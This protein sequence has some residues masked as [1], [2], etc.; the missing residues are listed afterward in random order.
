[1]ARSEKMENSGLLSVMKVVSQSSLRYLFL[2]LRILH[3]Y[4]MKHDNVNLVVL[5]YSPM[6][7]LH[8][9]LL[10]LLPLLLLPH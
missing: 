9:L 8:F 10:T 3:M 6:S 2:A 7:S 4:T 1:M 5:L